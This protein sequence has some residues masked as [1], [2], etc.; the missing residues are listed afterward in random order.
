M[1]SGG[2]SQ[3]HRRSAS[4]FLS[5][6]YLSVDVFRFSSA[7]ER[8]TAVVA[9]LCCPHM[10]S[11][12]CACSAFLECQYLRCVGVLFQYQYLSNDGGHSY[13]HPYPSLQPNT[14]GNSRGY[15]SR[16][17]ALVLGSNFLKQKFGSCWDGLTP[18]PCVGHFSPTRAPGGT[19]TPFFRP[20]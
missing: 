19:P 7:R 14:V 4:C 2:V 18:Y 9:F 13:R 5:S 8:S 17:S 16:A 12:P 20:W 10:C 11:M 1:A 6:I 15:P 3:P